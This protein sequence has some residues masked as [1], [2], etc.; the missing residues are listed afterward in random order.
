MKKSLLVHLQIVFLIFIATIIYSC[1]KNNKHEKTNIYIV[2][3]STV[4][5]GQGDGAGGL[6]GWGDPLSFHF[7]TSKVHIENHALGGTSSRTFQTRGLWGKVLN[8]VN[9]GDYVL[10]QFG[11]NDGGPYNTGRARASIKGIGNDSIEVILEESGEKETI[12]S[13]GWYLRKYINDVK[14]KGATPILVSPIPRNDWENNRILFKEKSYPFWAKQVAEQENIAFIDLHTLMIQELEKCGENNSTGVH[15]FKRDHTHTTAKGAVLNAHIISG[16]LSEL[17]LPRLSEYIIKNPDYLFPGKK[18]LIIIGDSTVKNNKKGLQGW[19][20]E[21]H[22]FFDTTKIQIVNMA[23]PGRSSR[24]FVFEG[25]W[26]QALEIAEPGD[27]L[28]IQFGHND[29]GDINSGKMRGS[30]KG[31]GNDSIVFNRPDGKVEIVHSYGWYLNKFIRESK[32]KCVTPIVFSHI[33]RR[34]WINGIVERVSETYG[35]WA[36]EAATMGG[37]HFIDLNELVAVKYEKL[38][39]EKVAAEFFLEDHTHTTQKGAILN[40]KTVTEGVL[41]LKCCDL[42]EFVIT[43]RLT[44]K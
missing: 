36:K 6:W 28:L 44:N 32:E 30:I 41:N 4:K 14:S 26:E 37:S 20:E 3:D 42:K 29:G 27:Y 40:A 8:K 33:P 39:A 19:G 18:R 15:F 7:D 43:E 38:G 5:N 11:H 10:I 24:T 31:T 12:Y 21:M 13:Y 35:K 16:V 17:S 2:G 22:L 25:L 9:A 23:K 34:E 1:V